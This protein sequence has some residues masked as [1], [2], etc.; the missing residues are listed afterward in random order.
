MRFLRF[1]KRHSFLI[2][3]LA[4]QA[5]FMIWLVTGVSS[6]DAHCAQNDYECQGGQVGTGIGVFIILI[7]WFL[8]DMILGVTYGIYR[9][10]TRS[11]K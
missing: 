6:G 9:L 4:V 5:I 10:A 2:F 3:F 8:V 1:L 11:K 7:V